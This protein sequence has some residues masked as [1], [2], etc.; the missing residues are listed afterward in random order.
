M[1]TCTIYQS[2]ILAMEKS[3]CRRGELDKQF[4]LKKVSVMLHDTHT[5]HFNSHFS[6]KSES[7][8]CPLIFLTRNFGVKFYRSQALPGTNQ[9]K[10][11]GLHPFC[12]HC[13]S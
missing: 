1:V 10:H 13:E 7:A 2:Q 11:T 9:Q 5:Y 3:W 6:G 12:I 4:C 8:S